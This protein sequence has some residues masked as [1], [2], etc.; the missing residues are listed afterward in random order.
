MNTR[1]RSANP[2][3]VCVGGKILNRTAIVGVYRG[4]IWPVGL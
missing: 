3:C 2:V 4:S 1:P